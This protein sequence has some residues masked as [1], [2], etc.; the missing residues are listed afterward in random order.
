MPYP[1]ESII[2][3]A[4]VLPLLALVAVAL[5]LLVRIKIQPTYVGID[6]WLA[7]FSVALALAFGAIM[8]AGA[9]D[10][11]QGRVFLEE[12]PHDRYVT[13]ARVGLSSSTS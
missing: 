12:I 2:A 5:R 10:G 8:M 6:D 7:V 9:V 13:Q 11:T 3:V 4:T 1:P